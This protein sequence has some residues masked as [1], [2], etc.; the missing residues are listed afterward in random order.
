MLVEEPVPVSVGGVDDAV[1]P[2]VD[3]VVSV[4]GVEVEV[5]VPPVCD[6]GVGVIITGEVL[7][8]G[9]DSITDGVEEASPIAGVVVAIWPMV[10]TRK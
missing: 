3:P 6:G 4:G 5:V 7:V 2:P 10:W 9:P 8:L 1:E